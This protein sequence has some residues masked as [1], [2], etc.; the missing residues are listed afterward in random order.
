MAFPVLAA[1][2]LGA[3]AIGGGL[4]LASIFQGAGQQKA[5]LRRQKDS[6]WQ[7]FLLGKSYSDSQYS[8][9]RDEAAY[10]LSDQERRLDEELSRAM[11]EYNTG[12]LAQAFG[13]QDARIQTASGIGASLA[14]EGMSGTRGNDANAL[15]RAYAGQGFERGLEIQGRQNRGALTGMLSGANNALRTISRERDSWNA[16]GYR[17]DMKQ[18][19]DE[20]NLGM[21]K[22]GQ[23]N[24]DWQIGQSNP[25]G[26]DVVTGLFSGAS[27]G[28]SLGA[29]IYSFGNLFGSSGGGT[30][31][32][33]GV[34]GNGGVNNASRPLIGF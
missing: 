30:A 11:D 23:S 28:L 4:G 33:A 6:A 21:A 18:A 26:L 8:I 16:G 27:S 7:Q 19:Q 1:L 10:Q 20:Y 15:V 17:Y 25:T 31:G 32:K 13:V 34:A 5:A 24:F 12:L 14:A 3:A 22:L 9:Q 29:S 2:G